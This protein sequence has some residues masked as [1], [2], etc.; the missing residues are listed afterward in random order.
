MVWLCHHVSTGDVTVHASGPRLRC[1]GDTLRGGLLNGEEC[2][3]MNLGAT[4]KETLEAA[5][6]A[7]GMDLDFTQELNES[8]GNLIAVYTYS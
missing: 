2:T 1:K 3:E 4:Y 8:N 5:A 6:E 7:Q